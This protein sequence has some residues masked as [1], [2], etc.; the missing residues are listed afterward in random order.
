MIRVTSAF[1]FAVNASSGERRA[2]RGVT[3]DEDD[4]SAVVHCLGGRL[5]G[6][7][8][9]TNID[10][11]HAVEVFETEDADYASGKYASVA[12]KDVERAESVCCVAH[13][14]AKFICGSAVGPQGECLSSGGI[15]LTYELMGCFF[16][17]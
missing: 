3:A 10:S 13:G 2:N 17:T 11:N 8:S 12:D 5:N 16:R 7:E 14:A 1:R 15:D 6:Y 4:S 9:G